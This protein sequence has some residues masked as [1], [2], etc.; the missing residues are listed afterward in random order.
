MVMSL[1]IVQGVNNLRTTVLIRAIPH[2]LHF[3]Q[4]LFERGMS[5]YSDLSKRTSYSNPQTVSPRRLIERRVTLISVEFHCASL[6]LCERRGQVCW[7]K[8]ASSILLSLQSFSKALENMIP[9]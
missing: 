8:T 5:V 2:L 9:L 3:A 6:V 1:H 7:G 4:R